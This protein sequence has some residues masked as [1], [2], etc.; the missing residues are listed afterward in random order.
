MLKDAG[1]VVSV[2]LWPCSTPPETFFFVSGTH[3]YKKLSKLQGL[4][5]LE[6]LGQL[7][8][9]SYLVRS[10]T[11]DLPACSIVPQPIRYLVLHSQCGF[12]RNRTATDQL[13]FIRLSGEK[14][15]SAMKEYIFIR[16]LQESP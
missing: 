2:T 7:T 9:F 1:K 13:F 10:R 4:V 5:Q 14:N 6:G 8:K 16:R 15:G 12:Q 11:R 3:I